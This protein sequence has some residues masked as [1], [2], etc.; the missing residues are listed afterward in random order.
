MGQC[1]VQFAVRTRQQ[2]LHHARA[3]PLTGRNQGC[4]PVLV[5]K[6]DVGAAPQQCLDDGNVPCK[7]GII[8]SNGVK[9]FNPRFETCF[10]TSTFGA[11]AQNTS[12]I[13]MVG[14]ILKTLH[15]FGVVACGVWWTGPGM[16]R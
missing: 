10:C 12:L 8:K 6:I 13:A 14:A 1:V 7:V 11:W 15:R 4:C 9:I 2:G 3:A 16:R 5:G